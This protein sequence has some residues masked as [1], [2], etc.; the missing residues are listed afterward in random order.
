MERTMKTLIATISLLALTAC[1]TP[2]KYT[3]QQEA[4]AEQRE[5]DARPERD[6]ALHHGRDNERRDVHLPERYGR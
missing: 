6:Q 5:K 2:S 1:A 3:P 4:R